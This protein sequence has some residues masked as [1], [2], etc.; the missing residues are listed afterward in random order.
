MDDWRSFIGPNARYYINAWLN[1]RNG[2]WFSFNMYAFAFNI[3]WLLYRKMYQP[4]ILFLSLF[5]AEGFLERVFFYFYE[6]KMPAISW[7]VLRV[8]VFAGLLGFLGNWI[9]Y[10]FTQ[11]KIQWL[12]SQ[13]GK[14]RYKKFLP[15]QGG[16]TIYPILGALIFTALI[17]LLQF[18]FFRIFF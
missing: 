9:Y 3:F 7:Y 18:Y 15:I 2:H 8:F 16:T 12:K 14:F 5:F 13:Y 10:N 11:F 17:L 6:M 1:I 4:A